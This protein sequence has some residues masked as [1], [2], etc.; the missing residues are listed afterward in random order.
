[1]CELP[2]T[3]SQHAREQMRER[4]VEEAELISAIRTGEIETARHDRLMYRKNFQFDSLW[5]N[6]RYR[7]KQIATIVAKEPDKL[8]V[9]TVFAYYF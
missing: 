1:M 3:I 7:I 4:G 6:H 9:V 8:I 5:R 2:I